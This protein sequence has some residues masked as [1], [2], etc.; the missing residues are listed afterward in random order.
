MK[1]AVQ[2]KKKTEFTV[3]GKIKMED[4]NQTFSKTVLAF[5]EKNAMESVMTKLGSQNRLSRRCIQIDEV[6]PAK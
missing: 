5:N 2:T 1:K 6:K 4:Q 3:R